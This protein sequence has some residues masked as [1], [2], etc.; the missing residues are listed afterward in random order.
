MNPMRSRTARFP[1]LLAAV[2]S[3]PVPGTAATAVADIAG[4]EQLLASG[5]AAGAKAAFEQALAA[6][7]DSIAARLGLARAYQALGEH[8]RARI[9]Y[10]TVLDFDNLP[11]DLLGQDAIYADVAEDFAQGRRTQGFGYAETGL[12]YYRGISTSASDEFGGDEAR[13][14]FWLARV[15]GGLNR[16]LDSGSSLS[17][18]LDYR[19]RYYDES[20]R[21][22]DSDLRWNGAY[23]RPLGENRWRMG[24]RGRVSYRGSSDYRNDYGVF[25]DYRVRL[26]PDNQLT[27]GAELRTRRYPTGRLR[28]RSRDIG[29]LTAN[30]SHAFADGRGSFRLGANLARQWATQDRPDGD[31]TVYGAE[32]EFGWVF[33][34]TLDGFVLL[35]WNH[36]GFSDEIHDASPDLD[37]V[38]PF[39]RSDELYEIVGGMSWTF[40][41]DW[42]LRPEVVW[43]RDQ[44]DV[45]AQNYSSIEGWLSV[46]RSF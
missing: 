35:W 3:M 36:E 1:L 41:P 40:A 27:F 15:G 34:D 19:F 21:R 33:S 31:A 8:A 10:E 39:A 29:E 45:A 42:T 13:D 11:P 5:D 17:G 18:T 4:A 20:E 9:E 12:G 23:N 37:P 2:L 7:P 43:L 14:P 32:A 44:S 26:D 25:S 6:D 16:S 22:N 30:W 46:R 28:V 24:V 38:V